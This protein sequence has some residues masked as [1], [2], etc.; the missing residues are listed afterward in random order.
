MTGDSRTTTNGK[1]PA[2]EEVPAAAYEAAQRADYARNERKAIDAATWR[3]FASGSMVL[4]FLALVVCVVLANKYM[5]DVFV[6]SRGPHGLVYEGTAAE[7][8]KAEYS[9]KQQQLGKWIAA[10]RDVPGDDLQVDRNVEIWEATTADVGDDHALTDLKTD[11]VE[12]NPKI[13]K[14]DFTRTVDPE[15]SALLQ[16]GTNTWNLEW[17]EYLTRKGSRTAALSLH[18]GTVVTLPDARIATNNKLVNLNNAGVVVIK[19]ELH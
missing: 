16:P 15:V 19:D 6:Y 4:T 12:H 5:H 8:I 18:H 3:K 13:E 11:A 17:M 7:Q 9:D 1:A 2:E 10:V 14:S